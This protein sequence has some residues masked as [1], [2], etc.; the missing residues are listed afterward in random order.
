MEHWIPALTRRVSLAANTGVLFTCP[1]QS[2]SNQRA[3]FV[4]PDERQTLTGESRATG[5]EK[6]TFTSVGLHTHGNRHCASACEHLGWSD[7]SFGCG[8]CERNQI[9]GN[10]KK[11]GSNQSCG[12]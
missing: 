9:R 3:R 7:S 11:I 5:H 8:Q 6:Q 1:W 12:F 2:H 4:P 10:A